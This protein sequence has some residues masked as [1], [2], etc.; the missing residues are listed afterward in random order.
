LHDEVLPLVH[1]SLLNLAGPENKGGEHIPEIASLLEEIHRQLSDLLRRTPATTAGEVSRLGFMGALRQT[2]EVDM[3]GSFDEV[4][5]EVQPES[6]REL[7]GVPALVAEVLFFAAREAVRNAARHGRQRGTGTRLCLSIG[8]KYQNGL[9]ITIEDNGAGFATGEQV[10]SNRFGE[11]EH[12]GS[13]GL[14]SNQ[15]RSTDGGGGQGL[16]LHSTMMAVIGGF[17]SV[18]SAPGQY[19]RITLELPESARQSWE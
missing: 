19:T 4:A 13:S 14:A 1:T 12:P 11:E 15:A 8:L 16:A 5:W 6:E 7:E 3:Q 18:E 2:I 9:V 17:L 10:T